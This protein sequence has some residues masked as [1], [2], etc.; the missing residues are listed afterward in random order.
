ML[1][2]WKYYHLCKNLTFIGYLCE[3]MAICVKFWLSLNIYV[4]YAQCVKMWLFLKKSCVMDT[5]L[6]LAFVS[7]EE[8]GRHTHAT[9][10]SYL[11][12]KETRPH[13]THIIF[14]E[15]G[16]A[17]TKHVSRIS[18]THISLL[19]NMQPKEYLQIILHRILLAPIRNMHVGTHT[20][21]YVC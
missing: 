11:R 13:N 6:N 12:R 5:I 19:L 7:H 14:E 10:V 3:N 16:D 17:P 15:K 20:C 18:R 1:N 9:S 2:V 21:T 8:K 4:K